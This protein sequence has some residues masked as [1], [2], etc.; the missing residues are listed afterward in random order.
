MRLVYLGAYLLNYQL[1]SEIERE[2]NIARN[3]ALLE[4]LEL[5]QA[6]SDLGIPK[7][8]I[9][10]PTATKA[11]PVQ[12]SKRPKRE[13]SEVEAPRRQSSRLKKETIDPNE[14]PATR[15]KREVWYSSNVRFRNDLTA[16][17]G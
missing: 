14:S 8:K 16:D 9:K 6:V 12:P 3:R 10:P 4:E 11:K 2:A 5:K 17:L 15:K 1:N 7:T 13:W